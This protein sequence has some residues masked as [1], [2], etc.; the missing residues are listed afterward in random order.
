[1]N[2]TLTPIGGANRLTQLAA[3]PK[4]AIRTGVGCWT[5]TINWRAKWLKDAA[6][7]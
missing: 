1:M 3:L 2:V 5:V 4:W 7:T 6:A